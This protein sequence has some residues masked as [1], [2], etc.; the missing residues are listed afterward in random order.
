[1]KGPVSSR[2][3][4]FKSIWLQLL[5]VKLVPSW[6]QFSPASR[7]LKQTR[8]G[9]FEALLSTGSVSVFAE[10]GSGKEAA[11]P[12][13]GCKGPALPLLHSQVPAGSLLPHS[14]PSLPARGDE[15][16]LS[17]HSP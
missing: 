9:P 2:Y 15:P 12:Q 8:V 11:N 3:H 17:L 14:R 13:G 5:S 6:P 4:Y 16:I 10:L 1:M 7:I